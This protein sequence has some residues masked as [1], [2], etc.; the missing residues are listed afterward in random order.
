MNQSWPLKALA[1]R[2]T[3]LLTAKP[4][5]L[6]VFLAGLLVLASCT[7]PDSGSGSTGPEQ[8]KRV[9]FV[10]LV[11]NNSGGNAALSGSAYFEQLT[12]PMAAGDLSQPFGERPNACSVT[13]AGPPASG[14]P[15]PEPRGVAVNLGNNIALLHDGTEVGLLAQHDGWYRL[16]SVGQAL[17]DSGLTLGFGAG[18]GFPRFE[19]VEI[20]A[21]RPLEFQAGFDVSAVGPATEFRWQTENSSAAILLVGRQDEVTFNCLVPD[22]GAFQF[23]ATTANE[24]ADAGFTSG[25]LV[26]AGRITM[27]KHVA[28]DSLL[29]VG[30]LRLS[31]LTQEGTDR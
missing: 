7:V 27:E 23:P 9:G 25:S 29:M 20:N 30:T 2:T 24:L 19:L 4:A 13:V 28:D 1:L 10:L 26:T 16:Q 5:A 22:D 21:G 12:V 8:F 11:E 17:P 31:S 6:A 3:R 14:V 15:M 18:T